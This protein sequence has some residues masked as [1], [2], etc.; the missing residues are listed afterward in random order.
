MK[1]ARRKKRT[2]YKISFVYNSEN[3]KLIYSNWNKVSE[4]LGTVGVGLS[5][6]VGITKAHVETF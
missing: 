1:E 5:T 3:Y 2:Y 4:C 6:E